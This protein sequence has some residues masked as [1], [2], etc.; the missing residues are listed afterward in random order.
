MNMGKPRWEA[1]KYV[2]FMCVY[3]A[4]VYAHWAGCK[5]NGIVMRQIFAHSS[6]G[7]IRSTNS[8]H[9]GTHTPQLAGKWKP[10]LLMLLFALPRNNLFALIKFVSI[11]KYFTSKQTNGS[12]QSAN[13]SFWWC[14]WS[15]FFGCKLWKKLEHKRVEWEMTLENF[16]HKLLLFVMIMNC[17]A[18]NTCTHTHTWTASLLLS[19]CILNLISCK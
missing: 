16:M 2:H 7:Y 18:I 15:S 14:I 8:T 10:Q 6:L 13:C 4:R 9:A 3:T 12:S 1:W 19:R 17:Y 11:N 5:G